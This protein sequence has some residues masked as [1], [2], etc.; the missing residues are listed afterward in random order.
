MRVWHVFDRC[1]GVRLMRVAMSDRTHL[2]PGLTQGREGTRIDAT[3][4]AGHHGYPITGWPGF[5]VI[6]LRLA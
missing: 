5:Q 2:A 4:G 3:R 6:G 1:H